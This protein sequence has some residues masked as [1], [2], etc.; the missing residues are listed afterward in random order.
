MFSRLDELEEGVAAVAAQLD[1]ALLN[2]ADATTVFR[3]LSRIRNSVDGILTLLAARVEESDEWARK[4]HR[5]PEDWMATISGTTT[6]AARRQLETSKQLQDLPATTALLRQGSLSPEQTRE[7]AGAAA[8]SPHS[9]QGLLA[10]AATGDLEGLRKHAERVKAGARSAEDDA[11]RLEHL[12]RTRGLRRFTDPDGA[13]VLRGRFTPD[14]AAALWARLEAE[15][16]HNNKHHPP[17][18]G[19]PKDTHAAQLADALIRLTAPAASTGPAGS[20]EPAAA[21]AGD[22][23]QPAAKKRG[24]PRPNV[25]LNVL[26]DWT[27]LVRGYTVDGETCELDGYGPIPVALARMLAEDCYLRVL[28]RDGTNVTH[29]AHASRY[30][31]AHLRTA[32]EVRDTECAIAGCHHNAGLQIDHNQPVEA[33]GLTA[34]ANLNRLCWWHHLQKTIH[35]WRLT[36]PPGQRTYCTPAEWEAARAEAA[37]AI[38]G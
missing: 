17:S 36:G 32:L 11:R 16:W 21:G 10:T 7:V 4:G 8:V 29:I 37:H 34:L 12:H 6:G 26:A 13:E 1:P 18:P 33:G 19:Q 27:A 3:R 31:P 25:T 20:T 24:G 15:V 28:L 35:D 5:R 9:E 14:V 22:A 23:E 38:A 30:I 2:T